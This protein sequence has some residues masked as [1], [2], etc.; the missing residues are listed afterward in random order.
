MPAPEQHDRGG[1]HPRRCGENFCDNFRHHPCRG[2]PPQVRGK[3]F[4]IGIIIG[5]IRITPAGAG[6]TK[7]DINAD[8]NY[9]D[10]P[11]RCGENLSTVLKAKPTSGSPPQVRGKHVYHEDGTGIFRITPAG[12]GKTGF[13]FACAFL[14]EDHPRRC[15]ENAGASRTVG[16]PTG[17]PPQVRGKP[18]S[19]PCSTARFRIT[20]AGA[21]KT[22]ETSL[23]AN[24]S[25]DHPRRCGE[26]FLYGLSSFSSTGSPPQVRGKLLRPRPLART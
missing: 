3:P 7:T 21:G 16:C 12:A 23:T 13:A 17:S 25:R 15:G 6:K 20:P 26:N 14:D 24:L 10:H 19:M 9:R 18:C 2:S 5:N 4:R 22:G 1:D 8:M 11:R